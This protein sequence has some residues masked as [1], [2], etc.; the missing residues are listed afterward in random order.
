MP[1][2]FVVLFF[3]PRYFAVVLHPVFIK[4]LIDTYL[5]WWHPVWCSKAIINQKT[6]RAKYSSK[7][8][9]FYNGRFCK[10]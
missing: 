4:C 2:Y 3:T 10:Q 5:G 8:D 6:D 9:S 7:N 1:F